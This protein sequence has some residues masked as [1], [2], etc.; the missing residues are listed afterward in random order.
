LSIRIGVAG[1]DYPDWAG[2]VYPSRPGARF[3]RLA[4]LA[5]F[6]DVI[7]INSTFYRPVAPRTAATWARRTRD[8]PG[9]TFTAKAHRS[10]T[11]EQDAE[12]ESAVAATL[13]GLAPLREAGRL[14]ALLVQFPASFRDAA[15]SRARI[16]R[17]A[18]RA[19]GWPL[20]LEVRHAS[21]AAADAT[22]W[23]AR[24]GIA[25]CAIDQPQ[26]GRSALGL[27]ARVTAPFGYVR[28][29]GRNAA[30]WFRAGAGRDAR[31]DYLYTRE[32]LAELAGPLRAMARSAPAGLHVIQ[33]NHFRGQ[34]LVN[35]LQLKQLLEGTRPRAPLSIVQ[36][37]PQLAPSVQ[38]AERGLF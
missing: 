10:W 23:L 28:L 9:F 11:H 30:D 2:L 17:L 3:D 6:V 31:Y 18:A 7:E 27:L 33:N 21:W 35:A 1:W 36:A 19:A 32:Q 26:L 37:Y 4:W 14:A 38:V 8:R 20:A 22:D 34:A 15:R 16:E 24:L 12:P 13:A 5:G 29:H 25:W